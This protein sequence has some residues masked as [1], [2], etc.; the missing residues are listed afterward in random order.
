MDKKQ[1][2][3]K[4]MEA[5]LEEWK[6]EID[7]LK[8]QSKQIQAGA[9]T[10]YFERLEELDKRVENA[11]IKLAKLRQTSSDAWNDLK[12]GIEKAWN[13]IGESL[14]SIKSRFKKS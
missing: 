1:A 4:K 13:D 10:E 7:K 11:K 14:K 12:S 5:K 9:Q 6:A 8:A 2:Y 3:Q